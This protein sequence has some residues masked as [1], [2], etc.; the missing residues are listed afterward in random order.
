MASFTL[1][2]T[3]SVERMLLAN[4]SAAIGQNGYLATTGIAIDAA[5]TSDFFISGGVVS[6]A[7]SAISVD[8]TGPVEI[9]IT[10]GGSVLGDTNGIDSIGMTSRIYNAGTI[11]GGS[12]FSAIDLDNDGADFIANAGTIMGSFGISGLDSTASLTIQNSGTIKGSSDAI[13]GSS[14]VDT[15][16]NTGT[17]MGRVRLENGDD[18]FNGINGLQ[19]R[20][21]GDDGDDVIMAGAGQEDLFGGNDNDRIYGN[22][23]G[24]S[25]FG[26]SGNDVMRGGKEADVFDG[27]TGTDW[28]YYQN[29]DAGVQVDLTSGFGFEGFAEGDTYA[30]VENVW[31]TQFRDELNGSSAD[32]YL[33]GGSGNDIMR[34]Y[35]G[36]DQFRGDAGADVMNGGNGFDRLVYSASNGAVNVNMT[37]GTASGGHA[38]GDVFFNME[39]LTGSQYGDTL[40]GSTAG[41]QIFGLDGD[42]RIRGYFGNDLMNGG[43]GADTF[44]FDNNGGNDI[45]VGF[46]NDID[47]LDLSVYNYASAAQVLANT[48]VSGADVFITFDANDSI[49]LVGFAANV[50]D[51]A[52]DLII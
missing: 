13:L 29:S 6:T 2:G 4:E 23:G 10:P 44:I 7:S 8:G 52:D 16:L 15:I 26:G 39:Y 28:V 37:L 50:G 41:N 42:D 24:D 43:S 18:T 9:H 48:T 38:T 47:K 25:I 30:N 40:T 49:R 34:G 22:G 32:N 19:T 31:G 51:L 20:V 21:D 36:N 11:M 14:V 17:I 35:D 3:S 46:E 27:G 33:V 45:V 12:S 5:G 1:N